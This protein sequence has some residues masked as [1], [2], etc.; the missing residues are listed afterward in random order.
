PSRHK[1]SFR[2]Q[3]FQC[4]VPRKSMRDEPPSAGL[5]V[6]SRLPRLAE[7]RAPSR[8]SHFPTLLEFLP[9]DRGAFPGAPSSNWKDRPAGTSS[10]AA[11]FPPAVYWPWSLLHFAAYATTLTIL[12]QL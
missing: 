4:P 3:A 5:P 9:P 2:R 8:T 6:Q 7:F 1:N 11:C 12:G 10:W